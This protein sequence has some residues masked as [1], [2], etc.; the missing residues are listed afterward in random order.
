MS[1]SGFK[2]ELS[3]VSL[4]AMAA[5]GMVAAWMV[6]IKYWFELSG[7]T[8]S[9]ALLVCALFILPLTLIY[10]ELTSMMPYAGG[11]NIW[12]SNAFNWSTGFAGFWI[13]LFL[14]LIAMPSIAYG[15]STMLSYWF[16]LSWYAIKL[17]ALVI[18]LAVFFLSNKEIKILARIQNTLFWGTLIIS[19]IASFI[20]IFSHEWT[21]AT[22]KPYF[23]TGAIGFTAAITTLL[24]KFVGF[25]MIPN[26]VEDTTFQRKNLWKAFFGAI[27]VTLLI[28]GLAAFGVGGIFTR[29]TVMACDVVDPRV[30]DYIGLHWLALVI[31]VMGIGTCITTAP[32]FW[33]S[34][35]RAMYGAAKQHQLPQVFGKLNKDGQPVNANLAVGILSLLLTVAAPEA[36]INYLYTLCGI[37]AGLNYLLATLCY[38]RLKH[39]KPEWTRPYK[40]PCWKFMVTVSLIF[41]AYV[42]YNFVSTITVSAVVVLVGYVALGFIAWGYAK[43]KQKTDP[44]NW[45]PEILSPDTHPI[46][47][48]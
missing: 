26:L 18:M 31:I 7:A 46:E 10:T 15:I 4:I 39:K 14:Y 16:D 48:Y 28:Y 29:E 12:A 27:G 30:A 40:V 45:T 8:A 11:V 24:Y 32:G 43:R 37:A 1:Q 20:F 42:I 25:E 2:K 23:P 41:I 3:L 22:M 17:I 21:M 33:L 5:G 44:E 38:I 36:W 6:E 9:L 47:N 19:V 13:I 34:A 35:A